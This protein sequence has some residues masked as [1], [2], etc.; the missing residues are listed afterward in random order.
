MVGIFTGTLQPFFDTLGLLFFV[1]Q[2]N[3]PVTNTL[4]GP[5]DEVV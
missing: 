4:D 1:K 2:V 5:K 3:F